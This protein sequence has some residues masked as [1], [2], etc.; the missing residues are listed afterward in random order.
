MAE[1][2]RKQP[3]DT[4]A[5]RDAARLESMFMPPVRVRANGL[6]KQNSVSKIK[7]GLG[8]KKLG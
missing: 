7:T 3:R 4:A 8:K 6:Q 2:V 1:A 5:M